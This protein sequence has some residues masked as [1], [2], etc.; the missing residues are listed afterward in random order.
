MKPSP[1]KEPSA[2]Y[3]DGTRFDLLDWLGGR[4][5]K[6]LEIGCGR[7]GNAAWFRKHGATKITGIEL[8]EE[9][10]REASRRFD[11]VLVGD[12]A[13]RLRDVEDEFDLIVCADVLEHLID[14]WTVVRELRRVACP[15]A[16]FVASI[17]NIRFYR[18][19]WE[20]GMGG[21]FR[22]QPEGILD[23]THLRFFTSATIRDLVGENGWIVRRLEPSP[24]RRRRRLRVALDIV[25]GRRSREWLTYQW[26]VEGRADPRW[27]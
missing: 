7:G 22:Y 19:L 20:I 9:S 14:P 24:S 12:V 5:P 27:D 16:T 4:Y 11:S 26:F 17:P 25:T 2:I 15:G 1:R 13:L 23:Q 18:A 6:V 10:A 21:G 8:D 3:F